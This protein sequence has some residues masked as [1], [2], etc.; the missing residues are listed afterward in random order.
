M[1]HNKQMTKEKLFYFGSLLGYAAG[2]LAV[3]Y[4]LTFYILSFNLNF[5]RS[6][7]PYWT[8]M[9]EQMILYISSWGMV[10]RG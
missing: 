4:G 7:P 5:L 10:T 6:L 1:F 3:V 2:A 9:G 8:M